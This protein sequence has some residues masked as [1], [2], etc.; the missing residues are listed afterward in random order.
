MERRSTTNIGDDATLHFVLR[1]C[2][3]V[4]GIIKSVVDTALGRGVFCVDESF[5]CRV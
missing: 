5:V 4:G 2:G 1:L 3:G